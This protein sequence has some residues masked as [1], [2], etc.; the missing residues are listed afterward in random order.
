MKIPKFATMSKRS[1]E[2]GT[3]FFASMGWQRRS[4]PV[5]RHGISDLCLDWVSLRGLDLVSFHLSI[6]LGSPP[7]EWEMEGG[8]KRRIDDDEVNGGTRDE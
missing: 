4:V 6:H 3:G 7:R 5:E 2:R 8:R 1:F